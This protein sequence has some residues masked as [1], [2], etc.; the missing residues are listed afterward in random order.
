MEDEYMYGQRD[1]GLY[2]EEDPV[3][4]FREFLNLA[5]SRPGLLPPWWNAQKRRECERLSVK[6]D[7]W[8]NI[9]C[10]IEK[11]DIQEHYNNMMPMMFRMLGEQIY[12]RGYIGNGYIGNDLQPGGLFEPD[13]DWLAGRET[14]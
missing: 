9:H 4:M 11:S 14:M 5:E 12:R 3:P 7:E 8:S 6:S 1:I 2:G 13:V 10:T